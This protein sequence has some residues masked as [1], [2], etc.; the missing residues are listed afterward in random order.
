MKSDAKLTLAHRLELAASLRQI[1]RDEAALTLRLQARH[2]IAAEIAKA[3]AAVCD[4]EDTIL[5]NLPSPLPDAANELVA[6]HPLPRERRQQLERFETVFAPVRLEQ[7][8]QL[9]RTMTGESG[10]STTTTAP[11]PP[12]RTKPTGTE[13]GTP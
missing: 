11:K 10:E 13:G 7:A 4:A 8:E 9:A 5:R 12:R 6:A 3:Q 1:H 2:T